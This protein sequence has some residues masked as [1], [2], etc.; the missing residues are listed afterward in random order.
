M[1]AGLQP[2]PDIIVGG[3]WAP[4]DNDGYWSRQT[5]TWTLPGLFH[6]YGNSWT[7]KALYGIWCEM[8]LMISGLTTRQWDAVGSLQHSQHKTSTRLIISLIQE[9][10]PRV[11]EVFQTV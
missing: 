7:M 8:P 1:E 3:F 5:Q 6:I 4:Y 9:V 11:C 10:I 2:S